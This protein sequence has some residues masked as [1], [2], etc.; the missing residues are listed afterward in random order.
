MSTKLHTLG[1]VPSKGDT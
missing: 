1:F